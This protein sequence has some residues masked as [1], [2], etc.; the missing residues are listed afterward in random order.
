MADN[1]RA[2]AQIAP[3]DTHTHTH[4]YNYT[5]HIHVYIEADIYNVVVWAGRNT[6]PSTAPK[7]F[8]ETHT[9]TRK[10]QKHHLRHRLGAARASSCAEREPWAHLSLCR[11]C[12]VRLCAELMTPLALVY[13]VSQLS[14]FLF[15][16]AGA[17]ATNGRPAPKL[18]RVHHDT[19]SAVGRTVLSSTNVYTLLLPSSICVCVWFIDVGRGQH[20]N[21]GSI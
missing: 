8:Q 1:D 12:D 11:D 16:F 13:A 21:G 15:L 10:K 7:N 9:H 18:L 2:K 14:L 19:V 3:K 4:T 6:A 17:G 5:Q 20:T